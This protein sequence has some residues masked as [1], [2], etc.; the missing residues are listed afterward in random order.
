MLSY[1]GL[2]VTQN[3][4]HIG[5]AKSEMPEAAKEYSAKALAGMLA[6]MES[7]LPAGR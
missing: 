6:E 1:V 7:L 2:R 3:H 5:S 4:I